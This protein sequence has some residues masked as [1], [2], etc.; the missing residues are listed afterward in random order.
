MPKRQAM[1][2]ALARRQVATGMTMPLK[3]MPHTRAIPAKTLSVFTRQWAA[4]LQ[5]GVPLVQTFDLLSQSSLGSASVKASFAQVLS[6]LRSDILAGQ[7]L[8]IAFRKHPQSFN[9]LYCSL[10]QAGESAGILDKLLE[11]LA[12]TLE[13]NETLKA[14]LKSALIYPVSILAVAGLL[15]VGIM[16]WVV[17]VF[18]DVFQS[19]GA[20]LP[21][22]TQCLVSLS[23]FLMRWGFALSCLITGVLLTGLHFARTS[24]PFQIQMENLA[25]KLPLA[26]PLLQA[27][28]NAKWAQTL[29]ALVEAG[30]P[31]SE[32]LMPAASA[33]GSP[34]LKQTTSQLIID[35]QEG[36][37]LSS[38][39][40]KSSLFT[41]LMQQMCAI[42]EETGSL[43]SL[44][45]KTAQLMASDMNQRIGNLSTLLE[46]AIMV[47][48]GAGIGG[49]L[50]ALYLPI[51]NLGQVF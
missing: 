14:K 3:V 6:A 40:S 39:M 15:V 27:A 12:D 13:N 11:R 45:Q 49:I 29:S 46:P 34:R 41:P 10:L 9:T 24:T 48:L 4:L 16:A 51:F 25:L 50:V 17:P 23:S 44:L 37:S 33:S 47:F 30:I 42:G 32:A 1:N 31:L 7:S 36:R 22:A 21:W 2:R 19:M 43:A 20:T 26:G 5:A 8:H 18:Q 28:L 35:I 38:A